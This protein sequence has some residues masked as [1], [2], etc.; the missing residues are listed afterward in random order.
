[1]KLAQL[2]YENLILC[3]LAQDW[4]IYKESKFAKT[5]TICEY[6]K[7]GRVKK[8]SERHNKGVEFIRF[9]DFSD[10]Y[11]DTKNRDTAEYKMEQLNKVH[12]R[13]AKDNGQIT[14]NFAENNWLPRGMTKDEGKTNKA[15]AERT[16]KDI[17]KG[18]DNRKLTSMAD[19]MI[20][21]LTSNKWEEII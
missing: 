13:I 18:F 9:I 14:F 20:Q 7:T 11:H 1:M 15:L 6:T 5:G 21:E 4:E 8:N 3:M 10:L 2:K 19:T 17:M 12:D 16:Y